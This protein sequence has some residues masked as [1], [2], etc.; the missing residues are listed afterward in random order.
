MIHLESISHSS[1]KENSVDNLIVKDVLGLG[2]QAGSVGG[3]YYG[4]SRGAAD[5]RQA[6]NNLIYQ[7]QKN[8]IK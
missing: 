2:N 7:L 8:F 3:D 1:R 4:E 6:P 5:H